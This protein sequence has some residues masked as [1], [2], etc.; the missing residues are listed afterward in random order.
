[1]RLVLDARTASFGSLFDYAGTFPPA[2][3]STADAVDEY[4]RLRAGDHQWTVGRFLCRAS[5][6]EELAAFA[7]SG[8]RRGESPWTVGV[9]FDLSLGASASLAHDFQREMAP[10]MSVGAAEVRLSQGTEA[11]GIVETV[12]TIDADTACFIEIDAT[13]PIAPQVDG[14]GAALR[15]VGAKGGAKLRC[16]GTT[17]DAF[18]GV[19]TVAEFLWEATLADVPF[20]ATAGLHQPFRHHDDAIDVTRHGFVNLLVA[21][22]AANEGEDRDTVTAIVAENDPSAFTFGAAAVGWRDLAFPGSAIRRSRS[23]GFLA[24]GTCDI[25]EPL[26][27]LVQ[28]GILGEG[29]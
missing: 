24:F 6:L 5:H 9:I 10:V 17:A 19:D 29:T 16:G 8:M 26:E 12:S 4:R 2:S 18:P 11:L 15:S 21:S 23:N 1:M 3:L 27:A 25:D 14:I 28:H 13:E 20:K 22:V 7:T